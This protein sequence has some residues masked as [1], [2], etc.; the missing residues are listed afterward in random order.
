MLKSFDINQ[1]KY[2]VILHRHKSALID[3]NLSYA[4]SKREEYEISTKI[5]HLQS[6]I[7]EKKTG[8]K[9]K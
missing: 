2:D 7:E 4:I 3:E 1:S 5:S 6:L 8:L 9:N